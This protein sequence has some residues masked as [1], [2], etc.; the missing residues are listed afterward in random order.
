[1]IKIASAIF[2]FILSAD[3]Y[4]MENWGKV[5]GMKQRDEIYKEGISSLNPYAYNLSSAAYG[6]FVSI[7]ILPSKQTATKL[8]HSVNRLCVVF[9]HQFLLK[10]VAG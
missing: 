3:V 5:L 8:F 4:N 7:W 1:M 6:L 9:R 10:N 2:I